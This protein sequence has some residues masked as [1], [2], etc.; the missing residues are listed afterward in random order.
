MHKDILVT[1]K[2][3]FSWGNKK[4]KN[5]LLNNRLSAMLAVCTRVYRRGGA[6][7]VGLLMLQQLLLLLK[8]DS[9]F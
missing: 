8:C 1:Q 5:K 7:F 6:Q 3:K 4:I 2:K 9:F